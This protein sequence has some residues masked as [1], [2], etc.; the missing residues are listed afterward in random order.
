MGPHL[1]FHLAGGSGGITHFMEHLAVPMQ[2][3][4]NDLGMPELTETV[5]QQI[6][7]GVAEEASGRSIDD[8]AH[9]RDAFLVELLALLARQRND[10]GAG[11]H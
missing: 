4:W 6:V 3:W 1:T 8:L 11:G 7:A 5:Q 9:R 10:D 2:E